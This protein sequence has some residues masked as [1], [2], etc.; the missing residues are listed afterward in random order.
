MRR[1]RDVSHMRR[2]L[3]ASRTN[4]PR[5]VHGAIN[6]GRIRGRPA[7]THVCVSGSFL[8]IVCPC[9]V[10]DTKVNITVAD[11]DSTHVLREFTYYRVAIGI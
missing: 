9:E 6:I 2:L 3:N 4:L 10:T 8:K 7:Q 5:R 11:R 1:R